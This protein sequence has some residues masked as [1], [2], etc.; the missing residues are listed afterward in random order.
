MDLEKK[1]L[2]SDNSV[3]KEMLD[4][5]NYLDE[6]KF[7]YRIGVNFNIRLYQND[8]K[9]NIVVALD[10]NG[11]II[12]FNTMLLYSRAMSILKLWGT[13]DLI[14]LSPMMRK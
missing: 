2:I 3:I 6:N 8:D 12:H 10:E 11:N 9:D 4:V 1:S 7:F 5:I 13:H 14:S